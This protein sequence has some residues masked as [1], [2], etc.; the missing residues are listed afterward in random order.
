MINT[1]FHPAVSRWFHSQF[2]NPS[3]PQIPAWEAFKSGRHTLIAA[4]TGSGKTLAAFL[5]AID[6]LI[7][8]GEAEGLTD[9]THVLYISPLKALSNDIQKNLQVP[10]DGIGQELNAEGRLDHGVRVLVRTGDT[11]QSQRTAMVKK[12]PHIVVTTPESLYL[13]LTSVGG[14]KLLKTVRTV[15]IDEIHAL[16]GTKRGTHLALSM[17]R[18]EA[19]TEKPLV[20]IGLSATQKPIEEVARFLVGSRSIDKNN[21]PAC[22]IVDAGHQRKLDLGLEVPNSPLEAVMSLEVWEEVYDRLASL[23]EDH[24]TTLVFVNTRRMAE[25]I[26]K[27]LSDRLGEENITSHHGSLSKEHRLEAEQKLKR[28]ELRALVATASLELGIDV[29][30]VDLVCQI[31]STKSIAT[32]LQRVGRSGHFAAGIPKGRLFPLTRD[33]LLES[34]ALFNAVKS[35]ELDRIQMPRNVLDILAQQIVA[36]VANETWN[37][38]KLFELLTSAYPYRE[39]TRDDFNAVLKMLAEGFATRR[40]RR[41]AYIFHDQINGS[42]KGR[43]NARLTAIT[44]GGAIPDNADY[45][46][47]L[48]PSGMFVGTL[49]EDF[50]IESMAGDIFQLGNTSWRI[51]RVESGK[52]RVEDAK[53]LPPSIPFW[54]GEAPSRT[55]ELSAAV[56][57]L[58]ASVGAKLLAEGADSESKPEREAARHRV[59]EWL[60]ETA[61]VSEGAADQVV[62]YLAVTQKALGSVPT[63]ES[64]V[65]ERFFDESGGMQLVL[66]S[67]YGSRINK[68]WGLALRKRFCRKFNFE[69]QAAA[70]EDAIVLSLGVTHSFPLSDVYQY[71]SPKTAEYTLTQALLDAPMFAVRWRWNAG[72]SLAIPRFMGGKKVPPPLL[73][74]QAED[75][76]SV[77]FPDQVACAENLAGAREVP[78]HPLAKQTIRD[79]LEEAMDIEGLVR[80]LERIK[81][82][83]VTT[84]A[85]DLSEPSPM[86]LEILNAKPYAFLDDAPLEERRTQAVVSRRWLDPE[87]AQDLGAL[88]ASAIERVKTEA[89]PEPRDKDELHDALVV[90]GFLADHEILEPTR[91][92]L[93]ELVEEGRAYRLQTTLRGPS[94]WVAAER[95]PGLELLYPDAA[96]QPDLSLPA[97]LQ[98]TDQPRETVLLEWVR[99]RLEALGPVSVETMA[100]SA[101]LKASEVE[102]SLLQLEQEGTA[103]RGQ[104][105]PGVEGEEWCDR[106]LLARIHRYTLNRL[107]KEI[108]PVT[109]QDFMRFLLNWQGL[110]GEKP[111]GPAS[112]DRALDQLEGFSAAATSWEADLLPARV[113]DYD[114]RWLDA[115]CLS[116]R[117]VWARF[118]GSENGGR[119]SPMKSSPMSLVSRKWAGAWT[120]EQ[121][122]PLNELGS[123]AASLY[124]LLKEQG[125]SFYD[126][127]LQNSGLLRAQ[128]EEGLRELVAAGLVTADSFSGLRALLTPAHKSGRYR[129]PRATFTLAEAGRWG[130]VQRKPASN[131]EYLAKKLL[132]RYGVVTRRLLER[133][134]L[135][136]PWRELLRVYRKL[137]ARGEIRGGRFVAGFAGEQYALPEA[138][139]EMRRIRKLDKGGDLV[140][141]SGA[142]PLNL[143]GIVTPGDRVP[144]LASNRVLYRD[145]IPVAVTVGGSTKFLTD[146]EG[147]EV[148]EAKSTIARQPIPP[149][150]R[151]YLG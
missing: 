74:M 6:D 18:L 106:R 92:W 113:K 109:A 128:V 64:V 11:P 94:L 32:F 91:P 123:V 59:S 13:L 47:L 26:V 93:S 126:D 42:V 61:A 49:N 78:D 43:R 114:H 97:A 62:D 19:L 56:S 38:D 115:A 5:G 29:G 107:R 50:A 33:E 31:G 25:R 105:T 108:E 7:R 130:L 80:V 143:V 111:E 137:E 119:R 4:P 53:G 36:T 135:S 24:K 67:P 151:A 87:S 30:D 34:V 136:T 55:D 46:V 57:Q 110:T 12:P 15:I 54:L 116:G 70:T 120:S 75:L 102:Q 100:L 104:F 63:Q 140:A 40:G 121:G 10:L 45:R 134:T 101:G 83:E 150:L 35:G 22:D 60:Q 89:W 122:V 129:K 118:K 20:R 71:L 117:V 37:A 98:T 141:V 148:W 95:I 48:E 99:S 3:P 139:Q 39:L 77:V 76:L 145:G 103:F 69:L 21:K 2:E 144:G 79:C 146:L 131:P 112:L 14:R 132:Q 23:I 124:T 138:V 82:G 58:R 90:T 17:E 85:R 142:D 149:A 86:S 147:D 44:S 96:W 65:L 125:A 68:A 1:L 72:R 28:G 133:E 66:H 127:L 73:R 16:V 41:A 8:R 84:I 52:V 9:E 88:D 27:L 51:L 81:A